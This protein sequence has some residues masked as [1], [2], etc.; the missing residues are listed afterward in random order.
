VIGILEFFEA[1][2][3]HELLK[4]FESQHL[5]K[6][7]G[8]AREVQ[9]SSDHIIFQQG[10][11]V[12]LFYLVIQGSVALESSEGPRR[13]TVQALHAGDAMGWSAVTDANQSAHFN[14]RAL[15]TVHAIAFD[16]AQLRA[17]CESDPYFGYVMMRALLSLV[18]ERLDAL[19]IHA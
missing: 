1:A 4:R 17:A 11:K 13:V 9:F 7:A 18:T 12:S 15:S 10:E 2:R 8:L 16:G 5:E 3:E 6:L 14:A 19:R